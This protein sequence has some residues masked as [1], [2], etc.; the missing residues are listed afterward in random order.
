MPIKIADTFASVEDFI[1]VLLTLATTMGRERIVRAGFDGL[2]DHWDRRRWHIHDL[3]PEF[4]L[5][6][7]ETIYICSHCGRLDCN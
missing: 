6:P 7:P 2:V 1:Q 5:E 4:M 3:K